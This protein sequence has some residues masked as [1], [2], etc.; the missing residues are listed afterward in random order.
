MGT[1]RNSKGK[2]WKEHAGVYLTRALKEASR[3][4]K[5]RSQRA[6]MAKVQKLRIQ[7]SKINLVIKKELE[8]G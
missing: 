2:S 7:R 4:W 1:R 6:N 3:T 5:P 8:K